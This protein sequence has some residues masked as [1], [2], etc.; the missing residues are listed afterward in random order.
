MFY[1]A[2]KIDSILICTICDN[3]MV[4]PRLLPCGKSVCHRCVDFLAD[5]A[6][7]K[8]KCQN[9]A[10]THEIPVGGFYINQLAQEMLECE[11]NEVLQSNHIEEF[12]KFLGILNATKQSIEST[13]ECGDATIRDHCDKVRNDMQLAIEQAHAKLDEFHKDFMHEIDNHEKECQEKFKFIKQNKVDIDKAL[14]DSN[15]L[16]SKSNHLL[17]Q[18]KIDQTQLSKLFESAQSLQ[19]KLEQIKDGI[20]REMFNESLL[21]FEKQKSFDSSVI[22]KIVKQNIELY[23]LENIEN[24]RELDYFISLTESTLYFPYLQPIKS[25][26]FLC[27]YTE[28][29]SLNLL[30]LDRDGKIFFEKKDLIKNK[31]IEEFIFCISSKH[32]KIHYICTEER[33][34]KQKKTFFN[35]RSFDENFNLLAEIKLDKEKEP[36]D[37]DVNGENVFLLNKNENFCTVSMYNRNLEIVQKFGQENSILPFYFPREY[38][39]FFVSN[40]YFIINERIIDE[41]ED[42]AEYNYS[43]LIIDRSNG[44]VKSSF[45][46]HEDFHLMR[47]YLDKFLITFNDVTCFLKCY[48]FKG[49]LLHKITLDKKLKG[50]EISVI[51]KELCF[52]LKDRKI[53]IF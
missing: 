24:M 47:L 20:Q 26:S 39:Q 36:F 40:K 3:K 8:I 29:N 42:D 37:H 21:K 4:D 31:N 38:D 34:L 7:K 48:N 49:D 43:V 32:N 28:K 18:F 12:K 5:T 46:I 14:N 52:I 45:V 9:C 33:H 10:K 15:E 41:D 11:A 50:S 44:L 19:T 35:L 53:F 2:E 6:K 17:Q 51:N 23:F 16:L 30:C 22:G 25:N 1:Q 13:L 27:L